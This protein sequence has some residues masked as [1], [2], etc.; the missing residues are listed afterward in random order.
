MSRQRGSAVLLAVLL[1]PVLLVGLALAVQLAA[2]QLERQRVRAAVD[3]ATVGAAAGAVTAGTAAGVDH[4]RAAALLREAL[5]TAL[6]P[7]E[8]ELDG[9]GADAVAAD[10]DVA[11]V[12][13]V[14]AP[15][16]FAPGVVVLRPS[17]ETR[18]RVPL[19][20]GLLR[21]A[22]APPRMTVTVVSGAG[23]RRGGENR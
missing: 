2:L 6:R 3:E 10:A 4:Q 14:P 22:A 11:V 12:D 9:G 18:V 17:I 23:L 1:T 21:I 5:A 20:T 13:D 16:P 8:G 7:L 15:D 19:R